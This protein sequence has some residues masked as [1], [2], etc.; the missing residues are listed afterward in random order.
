LSWLTFNVSGP[1][2]SFPLTLM[3]ASSQI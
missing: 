2:S 1:V 3:Y